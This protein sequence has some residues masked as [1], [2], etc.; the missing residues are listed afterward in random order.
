MSVDADRVATLRRAFGPAVPPNGIRQDAFEHDDRYLRHLARLR[1]GDRP[2]V[3][4][5]W[6]YTPN[7]LYT[8]ID[9]SLLAHVLPFCLDAWRENLR[10]PIADTVDS[11][12]L[13][14]SPGG[15]PRS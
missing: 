12:T 13:L 2:E 10:A 7:L 6:E 11:L 9:G 15:S 14:S 1:P 4:D 3:K 8:E 5:I